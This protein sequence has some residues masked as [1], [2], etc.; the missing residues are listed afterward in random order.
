MLVPFFFSKSILYSL[1]HNIHS[2]EIMRPCAPTADRQIAFEGDVV[3][4]PIALPPIRNIFRVSNEISNILTPPA[5]RGIDSVT[6]SVH[7]HDDL[8]MAVANFMSAIEGGARQVPFMVSSPK[9]YFSFVFFY[10]VWQL[11]CWCLCCSLKCSLI[12]LLFRIY[13]FFSYDKRRRR[14]NMSDL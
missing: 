6:I 14:R 9:H 13:I 1:Q 10:T 4:A 8:G 2:Y 11:D 3:R 5:R 7:G 12:L